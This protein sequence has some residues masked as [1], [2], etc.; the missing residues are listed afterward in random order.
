MKTQ[1]GM[2]QEVSG[3]QTGHGVWKNEN[4]M[5]DV[6]ERDKRKQNARLQTHKKTSTSRDSDFFVTD[7]EMKIEEAKAQQKPEQAKPINNMLKK[8]PSVQDLIENTMKRI[9]GDE[10]T[11]DKNVFQELSKFKIETPGPSQASPPSPSLETSQDKK[12][13][14]FY[15]DEELEEAERSSSW[16]EREENKEKRPSQGTGKG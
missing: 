1:Q 6:T 4:Q 16:V 7:E 14:F 15:T 13:N 3:P 8:Q 10:V 12:Q 9:V 2:V 5:Y 11:T